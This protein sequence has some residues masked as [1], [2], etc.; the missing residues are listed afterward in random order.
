[1]CAYADRM[2]ADETVEQWL[3]RPR[4]GRIVGSARSDRPRL[5]IVDDEPTVSRMLASAADQCGYQATAA[6]TSEEFRDLYRAQRP[7]VVLLDLSLDSGDGVELLRFLA[8]CGSEALILIVSGFDRRVVEAA[9][10]LGRAL[11][12]RMGACLTKPILVDELA[13]AL[14]A[15]DGHGAE[16]AADGDVFPAG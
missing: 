14:A 3:G 15:S 8:D 11:G 10:R 9:D 7:E 6:T 1:M 13:I 5:L 2:N 12:L 16:A 4:P